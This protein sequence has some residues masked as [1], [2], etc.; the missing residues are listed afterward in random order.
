MTG[1]G[2]RGGQRTRKGTDPEGGERSAWKGFVGPSGLGLDHALI[3]SIEKKVRPEGGVQLLLIGP[4]L[5]KT[6]RSAAS[7]RAHGAD[8]SRWGPLR[9]PGAILS[10][11]MPRLPAWPNPQPPKARLQAPSAPCIPS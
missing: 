2:Q 1:N 8:C 6:G 10:Y 5:P 9:R 4:S 3:P 11:R 7:E